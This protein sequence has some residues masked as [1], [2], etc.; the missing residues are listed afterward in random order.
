MGERL[1][2]RPVLIGAGLGVLL[3]AAVAGALWLTRGEPPRRAAP[4]SSPTVVLAPRAVPPQHVASA[5]IVPSRAGV[6]PQQSQ[7]QRERRQRLAQVRAEFEALRAQGAKASP[8][9]MRELIGELE[10]LSPPGIDPRYFQALRNMLDASAKVQALSDELR[11]SAAKDPVRQQAILT[12]LRA[13][14]ER[15]QAEAKNMQA[16]ALPASGGGKP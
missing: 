1:M 12:E 3:L 7:Q 11:G 13:L 6:S 10:A 9:K 8:T 2:T 14:G 5:P 15:V 16:Y 4:V